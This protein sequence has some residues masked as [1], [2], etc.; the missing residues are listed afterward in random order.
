MSRIVW[1]GVI[2][3]YLQISL[4]YPAMRLCLC[5]DYKK[6]CECICISPNGSIELRYLHKETSIGSFFPPGSNLIARH[7]LRSTN[8]VGVSNLRRFNLR[9]T[10]IDNAVAS[11]AAR[12]QWP[13]PV[14]SFAR[15]VFSSPFFT[16][17]LQPVLIH[18]AIHLP[19]IPLSR[20]SWTLHSIH[21]FRIC[22]RRKS[23]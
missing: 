9:E 19:C 7:S 21:R 10:K 20:H 5:Q 8:P 4:H 2:A 3:L 15:F 6:V 13:S 23:V 14:I 17:P 11:R 16:S 22:K 18:I 1:L 12:L